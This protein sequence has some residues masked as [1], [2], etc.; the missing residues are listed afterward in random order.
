MIQVLTDQIK[1]PN[2]TV[3]IMPEPRIYKTSGKLTQI[4]AAINKL[5]GKKTVA[6]RIVR[7]IM[8]VKKR[9]K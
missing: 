8:Q 6:E 3:S 9:L 5:P 7:K 2:N 4:I 1:L